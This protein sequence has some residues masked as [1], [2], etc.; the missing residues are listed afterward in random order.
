LKPETVDFFHNRVHSQVKEILTANTALPWTSFTLAHN[1]DGPTIRVTTKDVDHHAWPDAVNIIQS[2][3]ESAPER[4]T[5][6]IVHAS[7]EL[8][9]IQSVPFKPFALGNSAGIQG[10]PKGSGTIGGYV[11]LTSPA[12]E[13]VSFTMHNYL[14]VRA[15]EHSAYMA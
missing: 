3:L 10:V 9:A 6:E 13:S 11:V 15:N 5:V 4:I 1:S 7:V 14:V 8:L 2:V 12:G